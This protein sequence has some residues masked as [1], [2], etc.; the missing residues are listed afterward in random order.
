MPLKAAGLRNDPPVS[1]PEARG[2]M[3]QASATAEPPEL[4]AA[5]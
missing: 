3:L 4:P 5:L 1:L 2:T